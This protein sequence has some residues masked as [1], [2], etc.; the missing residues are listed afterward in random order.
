MRWNSPEWRKERDAKI[1][2]WFGGNVDAVQFLKL[3]SD[4]TELWDDLVDKD[5]EIPDDEID[6]A[7]MAALIYL[8]LNPFYREHAAYLTPL[9][10]SSI[11]NWKD[12]NALSAGTRS[13]RALAYTL[14]NMDIQ[15][16]QAIVFIT[17]GYDRLREVSQDIWTFFGA[18]QDDID[19][20]LS[21]DTT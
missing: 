14:R 9:M 12:A 15:I 3:I 18:D 7:M 21:G 13:Q 11:N 6:D 17:Q 20:W 10:I 19:S 1:L 8:P 5:R 2:E 4:I 16:V